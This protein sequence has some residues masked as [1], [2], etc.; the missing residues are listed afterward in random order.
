MTA[1]FLTIMTAETSAKVFRIIRLFTT[2][3][4]DG[5]PGCEEPPCSLPLPAA[6]TG[7][8]EGQSPS[9]TAFAPQGSACARRWGNAGVGALQKALTHLCSNVQA[10]L[11][12]ADYVGEILPEPGQYCT[13]DCCRLP[14]KVMSER[15][16]LWLPIPDDIS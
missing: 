6:A 1:E 14:T 15:G 10:H 9:T 12:D 11:D 7:L 3:P 8:P 16:I 13:V 5:L 2:K 4:R